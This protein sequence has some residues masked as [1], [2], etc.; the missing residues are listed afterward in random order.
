MDRQQRLRPIYVV[1]IANVCVLAVWGLFFDVPGLMSSFKGVSSSIAVGA[2][3]FLLLGLALVCAA[4]AWLIRQP[5]GWGKLILVACAL[6][7]VM[8]G[9]V[10]QVFSG[11]GL[12]VEATWLPMACGAVMLVLAIWHQVIDPSFFPPRPASS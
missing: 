11:M 7:W 8:H 3:G 9:A 6:A 1:A 5:R 2:D 12:H 10:L 4:I